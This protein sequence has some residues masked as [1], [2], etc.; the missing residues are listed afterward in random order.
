MG[1]SSSKRPSKPPVDMKH[2]DP[3]LAHKH[4]PTDGKEGPLPPL[5]PPFEAPQNWRCFLHKG[6]VTIFATSKDT[7]Y[8]THEK[9]FID[10]GVPH[11]IVHVDKDLKHGEEEMI[12]K[13]S[14]V[15]SFPVYYASS[16]CIGSQADIKDDKMLLEALKKNG[17]V[18]KRL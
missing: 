12:L 10:N 3:S 16:T 1:C 9:T 11:K 13:E 14:N 15:H 18:Q 8:K 6:E 17:I 7:S 4:T 2:A 5:Q